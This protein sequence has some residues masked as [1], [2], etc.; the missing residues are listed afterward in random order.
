MNTTNTLRHVAVTIQYEKKS[1]P[2][3]TSCIVWY[4]CKRCELFSLT[5]DC[6][7]ELLAGRPNAQDCG[8]RHPQNG[9]ERNRS[10]VY[11]RPGTLLQ[12]TCG[13][14][15]KGGWLALT[16]MHMTNSRYIDLSV[17]TEFFLFTCAAFS[18]TETLAFGCQPSFDN[19]Y[20]FEKGQLLALSTYLRRAPESFCR[21]I[22]LFYSNFCYIFMCMNSFDWITTMKIAICQR[23]F[24]R[25]LV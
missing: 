25:K 3:R 7:E 9:E 18:Y 14:L 4:M 12:Y 5:A 1:Q 6:Y 13:S 16:H 19:I 10:Y 15:D 2:A 17:W 23:E 20:I 21:S 24:L 22:P 11:V 8:A